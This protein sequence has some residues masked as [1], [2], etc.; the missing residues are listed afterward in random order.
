MHMGRASLRKLG[1]IVSIVLCSL[2][3]LAVL[4]GQSMDRSKGGHLTEETVPRY[5][6][7]GLMILVVSIVSLLF[8]K[9]RTKS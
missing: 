8:L 1:L 9:M 7:I 4:I 6:L 5:I 3:L 2:F